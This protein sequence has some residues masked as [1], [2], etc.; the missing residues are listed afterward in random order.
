M[1]IRCQAVNAGR[2]IS[3]G[4]G[5]H[6]ARVIDSWELIQVLKS[7]IK[8]FVGRKKYTVP[9]GKCLLLP[10]GIR[11]GGLSPYTDDLSFFWIH[12]YTIG[13]KAE[14]MLKQQ[15]VCFL[16]DSPARLSEYF[17]LFLARQEEVSKDQLEQEIQPLLIF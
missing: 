3:R 5:R 16:P 2:L 14:E 12:F 15:P 9:A 6:V 4:H 11:H 8:M 7:E 10:P 13:K 17:Q 1:N